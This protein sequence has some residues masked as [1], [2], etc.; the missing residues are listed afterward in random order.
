MKGGSDVRV[1]VKGGSEARVGVKGGS[2]VMLGG[3]VRVEGG[4]V[5]VE[6]E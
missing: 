3:G 2:E 4:E 5:R 6:W 1:G